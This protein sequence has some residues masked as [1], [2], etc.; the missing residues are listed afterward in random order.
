VRMIASSDDG[1]H[2]T[3]PATLA[4]T[5]SGSDF[6][7]LLSR[8]SKI[9]LSWLTQ[10]EGYRLTVIEAPTAAAPSDEGTSN[11]GTSDATVALDDTPQHAA[12][13]PPLNATTLPSLTQSSDRRLALIAFWSL[14]CMYCKEDM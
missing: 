14:D 5:Q 2:W 8:Q 1:N 9:Y 11:A 12:Q 10:N 4:S 6:P 13:L 3:S 7:L